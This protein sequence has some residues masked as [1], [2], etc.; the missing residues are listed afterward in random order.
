[1]LN[2][3]KLVT[4]SRVRQLALLTVLVLVIVSPGH[5]RAQSAEEIVDQSL[6]TFYSAGNDM[7]A[8]L[9]MR[10]VNSRGKSRTREI[11]MLRLNTSESND[12]RYY[13]YF[14][15]PTDIKGTA[16]LVWKY[17]LQEDDRWIFIPAVRLVKRIAADDKR[18][19]FVGSDFTYEDIS[20][21]D[22][23]DETHTLLRSE[24]IGDRPV[25]VIKSEPKV[26]YD[27]ASRLSWIDEER[28]LP[29]R[30]EYVDVRGQ[31]IRVFTAEKVEQVE[32]HW[33]VM[34]RTMEN[35]QT[36][37]QT[38]VV[39]SEVEYDQQLKPAFFEERYLQ[40]PPRQWIR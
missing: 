16:F 5:A 29:L 21:R 15:S 9:T 25:H 35:T 6:K 4:C 1:M 39:F 34:L 7:R 40:N 37:H 22:V 24:T 11:T 2:S 27:Y 13:I 10:L 12:Q 20:G 3:G 38:E 33:T 28:L 8:R 23:S 30:E 32:G 36:G 14:H 19:S 26:V 18:S 17:P 31:T